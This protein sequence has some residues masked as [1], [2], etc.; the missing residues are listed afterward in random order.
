MNLTDCHAALL[1]TIRKTRATGV[2]IARRKEP[3]WRLMFKDVTLEGA[4]MEF[5]KLLFFIIH[6]Y[7]YELDVKPPKPVE[8]RLKDKLRTLLGVD[9]HFNA[10]S[11]TY[12]VEFEYC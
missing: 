10:S 12:L 3:H 5:D 11:G 6:Q 2:E 4:P 9:R 1:S 7:R 8:P